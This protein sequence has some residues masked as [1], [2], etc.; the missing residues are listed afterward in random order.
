MVSLP[1]LAANTK[2]S[3]ALVP[4]HAVGVDAAWV[5]S[6]AGRSEKIVPVP[7]E[8]CAKCQAECV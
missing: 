7:E 4:V 2:V 8:S 5:G 1:K 3:P 6:V